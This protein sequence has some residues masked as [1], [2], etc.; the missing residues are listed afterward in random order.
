VGVRQFDRF[1]TRT[2]R[3]TGVLFFEALADGKAVALRV[4]CVAAILPGTETSVAP[5]ARLVWPE[6]VALR[7]GT[8]RDHDVPVERGVE[9]LLACFPS[10][11]HRV[12]VARLAGK[13]DRGS[14]AACTNG[15]EDFVRPRRF[16]LSASPR[17][18]A[19]RGAAG[20]R[21]PAVGARAAPR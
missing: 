7:R 15:G 1:V 17:A 20:C 8:A 16:R 13:G 21:T 3:R 11:G 2:R 19:R 10:D 5:Q 6:R 18:A 4:E 9:Q 14:D 12:H